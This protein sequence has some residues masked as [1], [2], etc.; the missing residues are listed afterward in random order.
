[1]VGNRL[2]GAMS[3]MAETIRRVF[4][5]PPSVAVPLLVPRPAS[6]RIPAL[7]ASILAPGY[8]FEAQPRQEPALPA[9]SVLAEPLAW[10]AAV[11]DEPGWET[12]AAGATVCQLPLFGVEKC[13]RLLVPAL[14][15][16]AAVQRLP[17][18]PF[19]A[20]ACSGWAALGTPVGR[21]R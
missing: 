17:R 19:A 21:G 7:A 14:P 16:K 5:A 8:R 12:W 11:Q 1:M 6:G 4:Q 9:A 15:R 13:Q 10:T 20:R 18:E 2:R 3:D